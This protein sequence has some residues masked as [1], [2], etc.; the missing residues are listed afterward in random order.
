MPHISRG[1]TLSSPGC[2]KQVQE[3]EFNRRGLGSAALESR[4]AQRGRMVAEDRED[5]ARGR[6][7]GVVPG[8]P[9]S[10]MDRPGVTGQVV[11][12]LPASLSI[13]QNCAPFSI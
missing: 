12:V 3:L 5:A 4:L 13:K 10:H 2:L 1:Q 8:G 9:T 6:G 7:C 11:L